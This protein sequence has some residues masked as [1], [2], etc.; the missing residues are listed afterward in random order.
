MDHAQFIE[1]VVGDWYRSH[2]QKFEV[3]A[4][5]DA[6]RL[7]EIQHADGDLEEIEFDDWIIRCRAGSLRPAEAPED[8]RA[9]TDSEFE[10]L[11]G[12]FPQA[13][14]ELRGLRADALGDLDLFD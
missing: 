10:D 14:E 11:S 13:F 2:G 6:E 3:V 7:V 4:V 8:P 9:A 1:P 5:D 12:R